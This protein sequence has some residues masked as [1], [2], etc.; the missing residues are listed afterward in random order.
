MPL[1]HFRSF[2]LAKFT[3]GHVR[4]FQAAI[5]FQGFGGTGERLGGSRTNGEPTQTDAI[6]SFQSERFIRNM[7]G[8]PTRQT[9]IVTS[10]QGDGSNGT[11][12]LFR[13]VSPMPFFRLAL[14]T[15]FR[16]FF[17]SRS[18]I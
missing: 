3:D 7:L 15:E 4:H 10:C 18:S 13:P 9:F 8:Q 12:F 2:L 17:F 5:L 6:A 11:P 16:F 1:G 14:R